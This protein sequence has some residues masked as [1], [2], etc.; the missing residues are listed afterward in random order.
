M[1]QITLLAASL[2][3]ALVALPAAARDGGVMTLDFPDAPGRFATVPGGAG[4][5]RFSMLDAI[6]IEA[7]AGSARLVLEIA[8]P[9]GARPGAAPVD[10]WVTYRPDGFRDY[11]QTAEPPLPGA[12]VVKDVGLR[13][14]SPWIAGR[15]RVLLCRRASMM[16]PADPGACR[17]AAGTFHTTLQID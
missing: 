15:F 5:T 13:G 9:P 8:L 11:W 14:P 12:I 16:V 17:P 2:C 1:R 10:A 3:L 4:I 7:A 6:G